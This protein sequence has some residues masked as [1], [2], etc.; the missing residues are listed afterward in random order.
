[1][2]IKIGARFHK[3]ES[4]APSSLEKQDASV[5]LVIIL[6]FVI[7]LVIVS[8]TMVNIVPCCCGSERLREKSLEARQVGP[9]GSYDYA[10]EFDVM[11][12]RSVVM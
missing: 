10:L 12:K 3:L 9:Y 7:V 1:M 5:A 6:V 2:D 4:I 11:H 8:T